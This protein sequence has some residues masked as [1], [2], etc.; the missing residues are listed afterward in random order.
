M[1]LDLIMQ[2][3]RFLLDEL[4]GTPLVN[5]FTKQSKEIVPMNKR[6]FYI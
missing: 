3:Y 6:Y 4:L 5:K 2:S 1:V